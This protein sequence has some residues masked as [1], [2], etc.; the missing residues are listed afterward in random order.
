M[1]LT[2]KQVNRFCEFQEKSLKCV[3]SAIIITFYA[4]H[5]TVHYKYTLYILFKIK[6]SVSICV[7]VAVQ[8][9][10]Y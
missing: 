5:N 4:L 3:K 8:M 7:F 6:I 2:A 1:G 10:Y 9:C